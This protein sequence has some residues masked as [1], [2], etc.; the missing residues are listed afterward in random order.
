M[1]NFYY[2]Y[3]IVICVQTL[4]NNFSNIFSRPPSWSR[5]CD[6]NH[7]NIVVLGTCDLA[8]DLE[9]HIKVGTIF[10]I[11]YSTLLQNVFM[12]VTLLKGFF[13]VSYADQESN[14]DRPYGNPVCSSLNHPYSQ[15]FDVML[16]MLIG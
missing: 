5:T 9:D 16:K 13:S 3:I 4:N 11:F 6:N 2:T 7:L 8:K 10:L 15:I 14:L 1:C 12:K